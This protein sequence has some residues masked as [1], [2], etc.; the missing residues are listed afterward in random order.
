MLYF[1]PS[2]CQRTAPGYPTR[3]PA[4]RL[5]C[6]TNIVTSVD[7][8]WV[9]S[10]TLLN[11]VSPSVLFFLHLLHRAVGHICIDTL[12]RRLWSLITIWSWKNNFPGTTGREALGSDLWVFSTLSKGYNIQFKLHPPKFNNVRMTVVG[13][14]A[15]FLVL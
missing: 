5:R 12:P 2:D 14:P 11:T 4:Q 13:D 9:T 7:V 6:Y 15:R 10:A 8:T 1:I 3:V